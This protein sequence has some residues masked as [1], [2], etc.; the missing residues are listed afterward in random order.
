MIMDALESDEFF[1]RASRTELASSITAID[2]Y[3]K[4]GYAYKNEITTPNE[5]GVVI[6][7]KKRLT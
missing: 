2:F 3:L 7:E 6:M 1:R 4:L 5:S